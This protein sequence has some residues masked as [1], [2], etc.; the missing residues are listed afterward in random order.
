MTTGNIHVCRHPGVCELHKLYIY[1]EFDERKIHFVMSRKNLI[2]HQIMKMIIIMMVLIMLIVIIL[3]TVFMIA[4]LIRIKN[5]LGIVL[6]IVLLGITQTF[7]L[8]VLQVLRDLLLIG[9]RRL[10]KNSLAVL[11]NC[12]SGLMIVIHRAALTISQTWLAGNKVIR[13]IQEQ[14]KVMVDP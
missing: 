11:R 3:G 13:H 4:D 2:Q 8:D 12:H 10:V 7:P 6:H 5:I 14:V 9:C 1:V